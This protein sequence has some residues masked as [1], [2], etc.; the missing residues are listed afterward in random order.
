MHSWR[1]GTRGSGWA[2]ALGTA[3]L[4][5]LL[6][7]R[8]ITRSEPP[9]IAPAA[10]K[11]PPLLNPTPPPPPEPPRTEPTRL[12]Q[13]LALTP[14]VQRNDAPSKTTPADLTDLPLIQM[15]DGTTVSDSTAH[16]PPVQPSKLAPS[17]GD[18]HLQPQTSHFPL[19]KAPAPP[20]KMAGGADHHTPPSL[21]THIPATRPHDPS[22][23]GPTPQASWPPHGSKSLPHPH[24]GKATPQTGHAPQPLTAYQALSQTRDHGVPTILVCWSEQRPESRTFKDEL[25]RHQ[26]DFQQQGYHLA[27]LEETRHSELLDSLGVRH[28]PI[29]IAYRRDD[30][31][32]QIELAGVRRSGFETQEVLGWAAGLGA[33]VQM[34]GHETDRPEPPA[35]PRQDGPRIISTPQGQA[36]LLPPQAS[37]Q[38]LPPAPG[39]QWAVLVTLPDSA[40]VAESAKPDLSTQPVSLSVQPTP[41]IGSDWRLGGGHAAEASADTVR[42]GMQPT[43]NASAKR[44]PTAPS[45]WMR[46]LRRMLT[47]NDSSMASPSR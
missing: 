26:E 36:L 38:W 4:A 34:A 23:Q 14:S 7:P 24:P 40:K 47:P 1:L 44:N 22:S 30:A 5:A 15:P 37:T 19:M 32:G 13:D 46:S 43:P 16:Q 29:L 8:T 27:Q 3:L 17:V 39:R 31:T 45:S 12:P 42:S 28:Y 11:T 33:S 21:Q 18:S 20:S 35:V 25:M 6:G 2:V 9:L 41:T 10:P